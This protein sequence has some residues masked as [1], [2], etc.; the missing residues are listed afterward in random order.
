MATART[1]AAVVSKLNGAVV[2]AI[3]DPSVHQKLVGSGAVP[4]PTSAAEFRE[5]LR[6]ELD[7]WGRV[8]REKG[9]K[10]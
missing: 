6:S 1:P 3:N 5:L 7:R 2:A 9:I 8:V 10:D 4:A